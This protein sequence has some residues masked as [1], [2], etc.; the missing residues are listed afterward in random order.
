MPM[1]RFGTKAARPQHIIYD[2]GKKLKKPYLMFRK[3]NCFLV[4]QSLQ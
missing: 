2:I 3:S 4:A 1:V